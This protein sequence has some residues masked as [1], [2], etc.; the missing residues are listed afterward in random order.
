[1]TNTL[2]RYRLTVGPDTYD[3]EAG[4]DADTGRT[5]DQVA[6]EKVLES[7]LPNN[8]ESPFQPALARLDS[9]K[10]DIPLPNTRRGRKKQSA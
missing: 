1:M 9:H 10:V 3:F 4:D 8:G 6:V 7:I 5:S 2:S